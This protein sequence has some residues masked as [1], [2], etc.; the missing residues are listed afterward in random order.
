MVVVPKFSDFFRSFFYLNTYVSPV[1][2]SEQGISRHLLSPEDDEI[3]ATV[4]Q[5]IS[6]PE[7]QPI[8][9]E[10]LTYELEKVKENNRTLERRGFGLLGNKPLGAQTIPFYSVIEHSK[11]KGWIIKAGAARGSKSQLSGVANDKNE[12][13]FYNDE[14]SVLRIE[15]ANRI[16]KMAHEANIQV[17][18]PKKKLVTYANL[19][20]GI[21][22]ATRRYCVVCKKIDIPSV[23]DAVKTIKAMQPKAQKKLAQNISTIIQKAGLVDASFANIRI[24]PDGTPAF[25]DTE[26][27]GLMVAKKPGLWNR[28]FSPKGASIEKCARIGLFTLMN[29]KYIGEKLKSAMALDPTLAQEQERLQA[30]ANTFGVEVGTSYQQQLTCTQRQFYNSIDGVPATV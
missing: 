15:M 7:V 10:P 26:P 19:Q 28:L 11:L 3:T 8:L 6:H 16:A 29:Q 22:E 20:D 1:D 12:I 4:R 14:E 13:V 27:L 21:T 17:I 24:M 9:S 25:I 5:L 18:L 30:V 2:L 23:E